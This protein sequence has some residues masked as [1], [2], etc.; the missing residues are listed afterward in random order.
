MAS[1]GKIEIEKFN[2]QSFELWKPNMKDMLV[3]KDQWIVVYSRTKPTTM[4]DEDWAKLD[5]KEKSTIWL[6][7]SYSILL[8]VSREATVKALWDKLGTFYQF[9]FLVNKFFL[10][11]NLYNLRKKD[12]DSVI[13]HLN[14]FNTLASKLTQEKWKMRPLNE[15]IIALNQEKDNLVQMGAIKHSK[16]QAL[17]AIDAPKRS[18]RDKEKG[19]GKFNES[20]KERPVKYS[21]RSSLP[22]GKKKK[23]RTL[24]SYCSK[25]FHPKEN[26]M[27]K[28]INEM[29]KQ[30]Q[31]HNLTM[32]ENAK[33]KDD[34]K[35]GDG[36]GRAQDGHALMA[37]TSTPLDWILDLGASNHMA[38]SKDEFY[39]IEESTRSPI[40]LGDATPAKITHFGSRRKVEFTLDST[41]ITDISTGSQLT[42]EIE[43]HG[44]HLYLLSHFVPKSISNVFLL[45]SNDIRRLWHEIFGHLNHKYLHQLNKENMVEG[46][47]A[48][49]FT[50]RV[51]QGCILGKHLEQNFDKGKAH[52]ASSPIGLIHNDITGSFP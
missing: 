45:Q 24:F 21:E 15:F 43:D 44:S 10:Q 8:K 19:K 52:R 7:I 32:P 40:Y 46:L 20:K 29:A 3:D 22:K 39:S 4:L 37:I 30:L 6:C 51:C 48:I 25:G 42:H 47:P 49:K 12:G 38:A 33:K 17:A 14:T 34:N 41:M 50:S 27:R 35:T 2:G 28:T 16:N 23:E 31:Q 11:K 1:S 5:Q 26:C 13:E 36:R 18:G 9:K